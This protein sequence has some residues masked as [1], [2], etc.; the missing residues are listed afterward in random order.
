MQFSR[1]FLKTPVFPK[2]LEE[3]DVQLGLQ[4]RVYGERGGGGKEISV[5]SPQGK[6]E[7]KKKGEKKKKTEE[8]RKLCSFD[9]SF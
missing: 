4:P 7:E 6:E 5:F 1:E 8:V 3:W 2:S 9:K